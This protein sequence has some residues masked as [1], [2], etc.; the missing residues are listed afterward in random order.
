[1]VKILGGRW[2]VLGRAGVLAAGL[3]ALAPAALATV[4]TFQTATSYSNSSSVATDIN[5][6]GNFVASSTDFNTSVNQAY[7]GMAGSVNVL[8]GP[9]GSISN[10]LVAITDSNVMYGNYSSTWVDDGNGTGTL[11][12]GPAQMYR[13]SAGVYSTLAIPGLSDAF[14]NGVS[15]D[16][17]WL[18]GAAVNARGSY[19]GFVFDT[20]TGAAA[21]FIGGTADSIIA[22]G[23]NNAGKV[24]GY[25]RSFVQGVG[26]VGPAWVYDIASG[27]RTNIDVAGSQREAA[28]DINATGVISGY[29]YN[30]PRGGHVHGFTGFG[31]SFE[32]IAVPGS[33][34]TFVLGANDQGALV[35]SYIDASGNEVAFVARPV[36]EPASIAL[37]LVGLAGLARLRLI[38]R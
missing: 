7:V 31:E 38:G 4:Y 24:V 3:A 36:P 35:G 17:H 28:R 26:N 34:N 16:G 25:D 32:L 13:Y 15:P 1:M 22:A 19:S 10:D 29:Y 23:V 8:P 9:I 11:I 14:A 6:S 30:T 33:V 20:I 5:N 27:L 18:V 21:T 2:P 37:I 12:P